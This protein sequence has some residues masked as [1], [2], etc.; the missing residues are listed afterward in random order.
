MSIS[1]NMLK[2]AFLMSSLV[3]FPLSSAVAGDDTDKP[4]VE[5]LVDTLTTIAGPHPG[6]R[7]NHAKGVVVLGEFTPSSEASSVSMAQHLQSASTPVTIRFS[8]TTGIPDIADTNPSSFPKGIAIRFQLADDSYTDIVSISVNRFPAATPEDFLGLI[9]AVAT[10]GP[11]AATPK[12]ITQFLASHP[13]AKTF[14]EPPKPAPVSFATQPF[15]GVNAFKFTNKDGEV[16]Y[17]RYQII[18]LNGPEYLTDE[19]RAAAGNNYLF[20]ELPKRLQ[21]GKVELTLALQIA[22]KGDD[23]TDPTVVWPETR[24]TVR[25]GTITIDSIDPNDEQFAKQNM[26]NPLALTD[27]IEAS[28][29]PILLAR[30]SAYAISYGRRLSGQ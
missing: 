1:S 2:H 20:E 25:L 12:P 26:F 29:D 10:S 17:G 4:V 8:N 3:F 13:A 5:Q 28:E 14:V 7:K 23:L 11:D 9:N 22:E 24:Q 21:Q 27:G 6:I 18:P 16:K 15:Y 30:P 19:Q